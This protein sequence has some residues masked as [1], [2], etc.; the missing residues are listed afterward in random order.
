MN[1]RY[2]HYLKVAIK[3]TLATTW[4]GAIC[5]G[6]LTFYHSYFTPASALDI[7]TLEQRITLVLQQERDKMLRELSEL[8]SSLA[9]L[10]EELDETNGALSQVESTQRSHATA[11]NELTLDEEQIKALERRLSAA[12]KRLSEPRRVVRTSAPKKAEPSRV[13]PKVTVSPPPFVLFD[14]QKRGTISLAIVG[15]AD[16]KQLSDLSALRQGERYFG[17][18]LVNVEGDKVRVRNSAGQEVLLEVEV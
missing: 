6:S 10:Q 7:D 11:I 3:F 9:T 4:V 16:A 17:W 1:P 5:A 15:K 14:V 2:I 18:R 13:T 8:E 12:E